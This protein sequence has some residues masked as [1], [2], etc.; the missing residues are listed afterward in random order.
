MEVF[1]LLG[2]VSLDGT[3]EVESDLEGIG[4]QF[5]QAGQKLSRFGGTMTKFVT[6]PLA[7]M[8]AGVLGLAHNV[9]QFAD[10]IL[11]TESA[12]GIATD[13]LQ[14]YQAIAEQ[15][16]VSTNALVRA[17][18]SLVRQMTRSAGGSATLNNALQELGLTFE[19]LQ[20]LSP[21]DQMETLMQRLGEVDDAGRRAEIGM[22]IF[23]GNFDELAPI[24]DMTNEEMEKVVEQARE[25]GFVMGEEALRGADDYR[26]GMVELRREITGTFRT[27][28]TDLFPVLNE[29]LIPV[30]RE[31]LIPMIRDVSEFV[32]GLIEGFAQL[33][34]TTQRLIFAATGLAGALGP[35][36][37]ILPPI[38]SGLGAIASVAFGPVGVIAALAGLAVQFYRTRDAT[39]AYRQSVEKL[40]LEQLRQEILELEQDIEDQQEKIRELADEGADIDTIM[41]F[42]IEDPKVREAARRLEVLE[43][44][45]EMLRNR[46]EELEQQREEVEEVDTEDYEKDIEEFEEFTMAIERELEDRQDSIRQHR[47]QLELIQAEG[48]QRELLQAEHFYENQKIMAEQA[49]ED[50]LDIVEERMAG[51]LEQLH[52]EGQLSE[53]Q[54]QNMLEN[55]QAVLDGEPL[56]IDEY[57]EPDAWVELDLIHRNLLN[58]MEEVEEEHQLEMQL[59]RAI[60]QA[61]QEQAQ[62][63]HN[64]RRIQEEERTQE[65]LQRLREQG[66]EQW[67]DILDRQ[68]REYEQYLDDRWQAIQFM[69]EREE[70]TTDQYL[71]LLEQE[72][73]RHE[74]N[75]LAFMRLYRERDRIREQQRQARKEELE[76]SLEQEENF[77]LG[78]LEAHR[79]NA[80]QLDSI[81]YEVGQSLEGHLSDT[82]HSILTMSDSLVDSIENMFDNLADEILRHMAR[83]LASEIFQRVISF[84]APAP[85]GAMQAVELGMQVGGLASGGLVQ[86]PLVT[87]VGEAGEEEAVLPLTDRV[88]GRLADKINQAGNNPTNNN[89]QTIHYYDVDGINDEAFVNGIR[90][91]PDTIKEQIIDSVQHNDNLRKALKAVL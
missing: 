34:A 54:L 37:L 21:E 18:R 42:D 67:Q 68:E 19:E 39:D 55:F 13:T 25:S 64:E 52:E 16:G 36:A 45:L 6:G 60:Y 91:N 76:V 85:T 66:R 43:E 24:L 5:E 90:R 38:V 8:S 30:L 80:E 51:R 41:G 50:Q 46:E 86:S 77:L 84:L 61:M 32:G 82:F 57:I 31:E 83:V 10:D 78:L 20:A 74:E 28:A 49:K 75:T 26:R 79:E 56:E 17:N 40:S 65:R 4:N 62:E 48:L 70:I 88:L 15:A 69:F 22:S 58:E 11:D 71:E 7:A 14:E 73:E 2:R 53:E 72:M 27:I 12:T 81:Y 89:S 33:D 9:S 87:A 47:Q 3:S 44:R 35:I 29:Q 1:K 63:Q 59:I 23:R